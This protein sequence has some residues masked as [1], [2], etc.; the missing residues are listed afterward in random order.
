MET[1]NLKFK[2]MWMFLFVIYLPGLLARTRPPGIYIQPDYYV[3]YK[4][5]EK[6]EMPCVADGEPQP[7]YTWTRNGI[8]FNPSPNDDRMVQ[9]PNVGTIV[10]IRPED[11]DEALYQ[12]F[13]DNGYGK[14]ATININLRIAKLDQFAT[15]EPIIHTPNLGDPLTLDCVLP[16]SVPS[17]EFYWAVNVN[18]NNLAI[19][20]DARITLDHEARLRITNVKAEDR[21]DDRAYVCMALNRVA[22]QVVSGVPN[23]IQPRGT[24]VLHNVTYMW[25]SPSDH[26]GLRGEEFKLKCIFSGNPTP[27][28]HWT[29]ISGGPMPP[30]VRVTS[31][32][33]ELIFPQLEFSDA[34]EYECVAN[35]TLSP[36]MGQSY[37]SLRV[38]SRPYWVDGGLKD[39]EVAIGESANFSCKAGGVP[40]PDVQWFV[41]GVRLSRVTD[42]RVTNGRFKVLTLD[43]VMMVNMTSD[44]AM[45]IQC[46]V[47]NRHGYIWGDSY[48]IAYSE[49]PTIIRPP[50]ANQ[51]TAEG[52]SVNISCLTTGKPDPQITWFIEGQQITGGRYITQLNGD[53]LIQNVTLSDAGNYTCVA[54]NRFGKETAYGILSVKLKTKIEQG[55]LDLEVN[56]PDE[57]TFTCSGTTDPD[58]VHNLTILWERNNELITPN[59]QRM[60]IS[61][62]HNSLTV[63]PTIVRDSGMYTCIATNGID[64][65]RKSAILVVKDIPDPP[66]NVQVEN[67]DVNAIIRFTPGMENNSPIE[68][69]VIQY[70]TSFNQDQ[71][72]F[73][74]RSEANQTQVMVPLS[75]YANFTFRVIAYNKIGESDPSFP[76]RTRCRTY[77]ALPSKNPENLRAIGNKKHYLYIEWTPMPRIEQNG[78]GFQYVLQIK[79]RGDPDQNT[80]SI[81]IEDWRLD[82]YEMSTGDIYHPYE[83][84][85]KARNGQGEAGGAKTIIGFSGEDFPTVHPTNLTA[86]VIKSTNV[87]MS[88]DFDMSTINP[89]GTTYT[90]LN[91]EFKGFKIQYWKENYKND[92]YKEWD[93]SAD[94]ALNNTVEN[95]VTA[96]VEGLPPFSNLE[97]RVSVMN[98]FFVSPPSDIV[99]FQ[100]K[101]GVPGSV[102][103]FDARNITHN[104]FVLEWVEPSDKNGY[105]IGYDIGYQTVKGLNLGTVMYL[106]PQINDPLQNSTI[107]NDLLPKTKYRIHIWARTAQGR[108]EVYFIER[109]T[110]A[111]VPMYTIESV[112]HDYINVTWSSDIYDKPGTVVFVEYKKL[113]APNWM[114]ST[115]EDVN[116]WKNITNLEPGTTYEIRVVVT[117]QT[118]RSESDITNVATNESVPI[119]TIESVGQDYINVTWSLDGLDKT[120]TVVFVEYRKLGDSEWMN[121]TVDYKDI[122]TTIP[123]LEPDTTYEIRVVAIYRTQRVESNITQFV[124]MADSKAHTH[125]RVSNIEWILGILA[126]VVAVLLIIGVV[127]C[128]CKI[129]NRKTKYKTDTAGAS[130]KAYYHTNTYSSDNEG[131]CYVGANDPEKP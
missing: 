90:P 80:I 40:E 125:P 102:Q 32:G 53:L 13:A 6:V 81:T 77:P 57:A 97:A 20:Y 9:L 1:L 72:Y 56:A 95:K 47:T 24:E 54:E 123:D 11:K 21:Q 29:R 85:I 17:P 130:L 5:G 79:K 101:P 99:R 63:R 12:C 91:G 112:G 65:D 92:T 74:A 46:N 83:I 49:P 7:K 52:L 34:G 22:R 110:T 70:N 42:P 51:V 94:D 82:H 60:V 106:Q 121:S 84:T 41:N 114:N 15:A 103:H 122:R 98:N 113:G 89:A 55:P 62:Y 131:Q 45:V 88:W 30:G 36:R 44:D 87:T 59:D 3:Y 64:S 2:R 115:D 73:G 39:A 25:G 93:I 118:L 86:K 78:P 58:E 19:N 96:L 50:E 33:Q 48:L 14:S 23:F 117:Y 100:T 128:Y 71:W 43:T 38:E 18:G 68:Y 109:A 76:S 107:L 104:H 66:F 4:V 10:I 124:T 28:V 127:Y 67:C 75:P 69:F 129:V 8:D 31:F 116:T 26:Y 27:V 61:D 108:G 119:Y 126:A 37:V 105:I 120:G 111:Y 16:N 35:N